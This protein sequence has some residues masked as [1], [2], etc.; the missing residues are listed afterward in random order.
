M[1][2]Y[3]FRS[4]S[5]LF[6]CIT[7]IP[8]AD[9]TPAYEHQPLHTMVPRNTFPL[10]TPFPACYKKVMSNPT[11]EEQI[12]MAGLAYGRRHDISY[13][14]GLI[15]Q[16]LGAAV[17]AVLYPLG[18]PFYTIGIML[19]NAGA[20]L[21]GIYLLVWMSWV[22]K[23]ILGSILIGIPLQVLGW[24]YA[25]EQYAVSVIIAGIGLV[26]VGAGGMA[27]KEA[28]CFAYREGWTLLWLYPILIVA[29]L[30]GKEHHIFN[31]LG[32][33]AAFLLLL[34]LTGKK[35]KQPLLSKCTTG[36][37][38]PPTRQQTADDQTPD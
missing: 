11:L 33:S 5:S 25:P 26:C 23:I 12:A 34:S 19:F 29:N 9:P 17:L 28:Y 36:V 13:R 37:C 30:M 14:A 31:A 8:K 20:L 18:S 24:M 22:K 32:F 7:M 35:L 10:A 4:Y 15:V 6:I 1:Q 27:G 16:M 21:S 3:S 2:N 38:V